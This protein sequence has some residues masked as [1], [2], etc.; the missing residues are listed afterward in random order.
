MKFEI[1][2]SGHDL[3]AKDYV[4]CV[5]EKDNDGPA[6]IKGFKF[7]KEIS[8]KLQENWKNGEYKYP[9]LRNKRGFLKVR[10]YSI[11]LYH[12]FKEL[13]IKEK[14]SLTICR[15]FKGHENDIETNLNFFLREELRLDVGKPLHQRLPPTSKAHWYGYLMLKDSENLLNTYVDISLEDIERYL[16]LKSKL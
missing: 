14:V 3:F 1:D 6:R 15:D 13:N 8:E 7:S 5:A 16:K 12:I 11:I 2:V 10:I 9:Y 4:I